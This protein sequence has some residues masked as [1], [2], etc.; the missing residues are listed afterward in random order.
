MPNWK[1]VIVSGS[2]AELNSLYVTNSVTS[3]TLSTSSDLYLNNTVLSNQENTDV[4]TGTETVATV[5]IADY[6]AAFFDYVIKNGINL[7]AGT[8]Y[9]VHDG[10]NIEYTETSTQDLGDTTDVTLSVDISGADLRLLATTITDNWIIKTLIR[11][12]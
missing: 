8:V 4:D 7:R 11:A 9:A 6:D 1:K 10:T 2:N 12:I 5:A 3:S